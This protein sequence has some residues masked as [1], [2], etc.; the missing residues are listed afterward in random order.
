MD[1][2]DTVVVGAGVVGLAAARALALAGLEV[3][4]LE[5]NEAIGME[6][7][8]RNSE[9]I[10]A[11]IYYPTGSLKAALCVAGKKALYEYCQ[12]RGVPHARLGKV[13]VA[14][15]EDQLPELGRIRAQGLAN[16]AGELA[17][18]DE[19]QVAGLE[20]EVRAVAAIHSETTG[21]IDSHAYMLALLGDLEAH[22]G[23][24]VTRSTVEVLEPVAGGIRIHTDDLRIEARQIVNAAGLH[25]PRF[26]AQMGVDVAAHYAR[27]RYYTYSG[28]APFSRLVYPVP[29]PGGLG[30]HVT[31]DLGGTTRFGPDVAWVDEVDYTFD[32]TAREAF[33]AAI[34]SYYPA[35]DVSRLQPGYTGIRPKISGKGEPAAD[36]RIETPLEHGVAGLVHLL[37]IESPGLTASLAIADRVA[38]ALSC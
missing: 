30:V 2:V 1:R 25:A 3:L 12:V 32:D 13:I 16:G 21:I 35:L 18:L 28:K 11:G 17:V 5:K 24:L 34:R 6:T 36:F 15:S 29:E 19:A 9:V 8:A 7:S 38:E 14:S 4:V 23:L 31:L 10:H 33:A 37:G 22:G 20:P 26:A 27:G